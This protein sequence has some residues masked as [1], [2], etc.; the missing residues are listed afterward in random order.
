[1]EL[2]TSNL[3]LFGPLLNTAAVLSLSLIYVTEFEYNYNYFKFIDS[4]NELNFHQ[5]EIFIK[6]GCYPITHIQN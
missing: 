4:F 3:A 5:N 2:S 1:M 6:Y